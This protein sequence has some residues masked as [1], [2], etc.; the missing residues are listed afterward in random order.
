MDGFPAEAGLARFHVVWETLRTGE[1]A[2]DRAVKK[3]VWIGVLGFIIPLSAANGL[4]VGTPLPDFQLP[5]I[6][7]G[8]PVALNE[9]INKK[10]IIVHFWKSR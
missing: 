7:S 3:W 4:Q 10:I 1:F 6:G 5:A 8:R 2:L 9:F